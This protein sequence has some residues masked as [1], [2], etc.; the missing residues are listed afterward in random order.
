ME[1]RSIVDS[2]LQGIT[3]LLKFVTAALPGSGVLISPN[4]EQ[5][6]IGRLTEMGNDLAKGPG[7]S[8]SQIGEIETFRDYLRDVRMFYVLS[9]A[10]SMLPS[11][12]ETFTG[13]FDTLDFMERTA[14]P[15]FW[16]SWKRVSKIEADPTDLQ[17]LVAEM[18]DFINIQQGMMFGK[19]ARFLDVNVRDKGIHFVRSAV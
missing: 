3:C 7:E 8:S 18:E 13:S 6:T 14:T 2:S 5:N 10:F 12:S 17:G 19:V 1:F 15:E 9:A 4:F 11:Y 16:N